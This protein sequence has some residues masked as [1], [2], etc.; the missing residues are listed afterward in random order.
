MRTLEVG[1]WIRGIDKEL[2]CENDVWSEKN[3]E[4]GH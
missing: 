3:I 2:R 1:R 4:N